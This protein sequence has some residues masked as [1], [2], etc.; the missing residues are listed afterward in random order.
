MLLLLLLYPTAI[1]VWF[2]YIHGVP[3]FGPS[4]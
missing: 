1:D 3:D 2:Y 4:K